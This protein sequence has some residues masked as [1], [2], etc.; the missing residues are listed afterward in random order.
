[1]T[2]PALVA[3]QAEAFAALA[4]RSRAMTLFVPSHGKGFVAPADGA[5]KVAFGFADGGGA[6]LVPR[7]TAPA[8]AVATINVP[9]R[10]R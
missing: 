4:R 3:E 10:I 5:V 2:D 7:A 6:P 1:M 8:T 9:A